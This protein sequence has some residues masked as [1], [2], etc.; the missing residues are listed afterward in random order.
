MIFSIN[1]YTLAYLPLLTPLP[2]HFQCF[3]F[4]W[5]HSF[6]A[7]NESRTNIG[8]VKPQTNEWHYCVP[9]L[10]K[11]SKLLSCIHILSF[12]SFISCCACWSGA[13]FFPAF[14]LS[15]SPFLWLLL[16]FSSLAY[17]LVCAC[18]VVVVVAL[19]V[20]LFICLLLLFSLSRFILLS[21]YIYGKRVY[22]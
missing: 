13:P 19:F 5:W 15:L 11:R 2:Y 6:V 3:F 8:K 16:C 1:C 22:V 14:Y 21:A 18:V 4:V 10:F 20:F 17:N 9:G 12:V 7:Q